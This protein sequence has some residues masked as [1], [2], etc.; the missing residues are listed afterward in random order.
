[1][2]VGTTLLR[3]D[4]LPYFS[5]QFGRGGLSATFACDLMQLPTGAGITLDVVVEHKN[6]E[7]TAFAPLVAFPTMSA[8]GVQPVA[9]SGIKEQLRFVYTVGGANA[10]DA[11]HFNMLA[12]QWRPY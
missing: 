1:M 6:A 3:L 2:V 8:P 9:A 11:V 10:S 12:P 4:G 5:P 7:D